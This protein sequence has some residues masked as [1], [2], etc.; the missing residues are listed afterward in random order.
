MAE[1]EYKLGISQI[2][3]VSK[4]LYKE[5]EGKTNLSIEFPVSKSKSCKMPL[6]F[7]E[8]GKVSK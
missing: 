8:L 2:F 1:S 6:K 3:F 7:G 5:K 4:P